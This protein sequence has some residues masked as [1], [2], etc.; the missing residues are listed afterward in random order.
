MGIDI[1]GL[2]YKT[3]KIQ[4]IE[5]QN[6]ENTKRRITK[7]R[8]QNVESYKRSIYKTLKVTKGRITKGRKF[9]NLIK[10]RVK[11]YKKPKK[12]GKYAEKFFHG[13]S[14]RWSPG[15]FSSS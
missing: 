2:C 12:E 8:L 7:R 11:N 10:E 6:V 14:K 13:E 4:N 5:L 15:F 3:S 9:Q 1:P